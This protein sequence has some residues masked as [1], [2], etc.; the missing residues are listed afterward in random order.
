MKQQYTVDQHDIS[1]VTS[2][3][4]KDLST[5]PSKKIN[6]SDLESY[7][8][9]LERKSI[10]DFSSPYPP[11]YNDLS[12]TTKTFALN[13]IIERSEQGNEILPP[14]S[15]TLF[16]TG[17]LDLKVELI[18]PFVQSSN[19]SWKKVYIELNNTQ[20]NVYSIKSTN[21]NCN[22]K[23]KELFKDDYYRNQL[24]SAEKIERQK[25]KEKRRE[26]LRSNS[27]TSFSSDVDLSFDQQSIS[28]SSS[29]NTSFYNSPDRDLFF[30]FQNSNSLFKES[31][32][33]KDQLDSSSLIPTLS[34]K[35]GK[36]LKSYTLQM[37]N[38]GIAKD[39]KKKPYV[40]RLRIENEQ[41]LL[42]CLSIKDMINWYVDLST[43]ADISLPLE[44]RQ[45]PQLK[46]VPTGFQTFIRQNWETNHDNEIATNLSDSGS[47][48]TSQHL[49]SDNECLSSSSSLTRSSSYENDVKLPLPQPNS[50]FTT[51]CD[52]ETLNYL[53]EKQEEESLF[54]FRKCMKS[55]VSK[56]K[57]RGNTLIMTERL[58]PNLD[59]DNSETMINSRKSKRSSILLQLKSPTSTSNL[60][61]KQ[62]IGS[63]RG[64]L[65][66]NEHLMN[67]I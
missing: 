63:C 5:I 58:S 54:Y 4:I 49:F 42:R 53:Y 29:I 39:Y 52:Q 21:T 6:K 60:F 24:K 8:K 7:F 10:F 61:S 56:E 26:R 3:K 19:R 55:L 22:N 31:F 37:L 15:Q 34:L 57:W 27:L 17:I 2:I 16:K 33:F 67:V 40:L 50:T 43:G 28:S 65:V 23:L 51:N 44:L 13:P 64:Y 25:L 36:L 30:P 9:D 1:N 45:F 62:Q 14:Y 48:I 46:T 66:G 59:N 47:S 38:I 35:K 18:S 41:V 20:L 12:P 11:N 32:N